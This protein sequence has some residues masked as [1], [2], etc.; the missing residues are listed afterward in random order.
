[1]SDDV[2]VSLLT[3]V[4][5]SPS[6]MQFRH[7]AATAVLPR[8]RPDA[9]QSHQLHILQRPCQLSAEDLPCVHHI[10]PVI[11]P[12]SP[13]SLAAFRRMPRVMVKL[14]RHID[15]SSLFM[16]AQY[17]RPVQVVCLC[18]RGLYQI[19]RTDSADKPL[20]P[21][22]KT[23]TALIC[24]QRCPIEKPFTAGERPLDQPGS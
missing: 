4:P 11:Q 13:A 23:S 22:S 12:P 21:F 2:Y 6:K 9:G 17:R 14:L 16:A 20:A 3:L 5:V 15:G 18:S 10:P 24:S 19:H 7:D 1:M 8:R